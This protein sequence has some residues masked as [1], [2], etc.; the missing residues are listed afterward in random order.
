M[1]SATTDIEHPDPD[2][3]WDDL[4]CDTPACD[5]R[6]DDGEGYDGYCGNC[7]DQLEAAGHWS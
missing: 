3:D 7:A 4:S 2:D 5:G 6:L 1:T